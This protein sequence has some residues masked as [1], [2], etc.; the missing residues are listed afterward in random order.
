MKSKLSKN[1]TGIQQNN[2]KVI[3]LLDLNE[4]TNQEA[5]MITGGLNELVGSISVNWDTGGGTGGGTGSSG[6]TWCEANSK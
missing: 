1:Q 3:Q 2:S 6:G 4:L 5:E